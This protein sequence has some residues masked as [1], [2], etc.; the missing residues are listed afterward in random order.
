MSYRQLTQ[1]QRYQIGAGVRIGIKMSEIARQI[2]VHRSTVTREIGR[3]SS[4]RWGYNPSRACRAARE[5]HR[6]KRK[7]R[8]DNETWARIETLL[9]TQWSPEQISKR[10]KL[11]GLKSV[12]HETIYRHVYRD[13]QEGG[14][15]YKHLRR[16]HRYRKRIHKY[17]KRFGWDTRRSISE[18]PA[19]VDSRMRIGDWEADTIIGHGRRG[20][21]LSLVE[22]RSRLCLLEKL[23]GTSSQK[24]AEAA[25]R[26]LM[27]H[28]DKV[29]TITSDNGIEFTR[30]QRIA[31]VL[32]ADFFFADPYS[33]W[34]R[35]TERK[36]QWPCPPILP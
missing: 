12:S 6:E 32:D 28:K 19:V 13:K 23:P 36:Y 1:E 29:F 5:R 27:P 16:R 30:H 8:V 33:S 26:Q 21:I 24:L 10:L 3:N 11:E 17:C 7:Y 14:E 15:M 4:E 20:A 35:G 9:R 18:R 2:G 31:E 22:R 25:C 34:Q